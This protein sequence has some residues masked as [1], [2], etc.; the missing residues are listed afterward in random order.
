MNVHK[1][2]SLGLQVFKDES[3][4]NHCGN[5]VTVNDSYGPPIPFMECR[6]LVTLNDLWSPQ[7]L[8]GMWEPCYRVPAH[9][10][11]DFFRMAMMGTL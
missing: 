1:Q 11:C 9:V 5:L 7:T 8:Y 3:S 10:Q 4:S 6:N 2:S